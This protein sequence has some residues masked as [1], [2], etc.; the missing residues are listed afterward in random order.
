MR[1]KN[2]L[3]FFAERQLISKSGH[4]GNRLGVESVS[5]KA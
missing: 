1:G 5:D 3:I 2:F 4:Q